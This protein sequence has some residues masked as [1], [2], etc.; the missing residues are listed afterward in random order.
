MRSIRPDASQKFTRDEM[1]QVTTKL[2]ALWNNI[3]AKEM[4]EVKEEAEKCMAA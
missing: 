4:K 1:Q 3:R 2:A